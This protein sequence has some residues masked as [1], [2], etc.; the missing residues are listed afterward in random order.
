MTAFQKL[1]KSEKQCF[2]HRRQGLFPSNKLPSGVLAYVEFK[3]ERQNIRA[4]DSTMFVCYGNKYSKKSK[5]EL[6]RIFR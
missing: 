6:G 4:V 5:H 3:R 1:L 2:N